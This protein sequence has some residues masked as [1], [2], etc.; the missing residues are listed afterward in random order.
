VEGPSAPGKW[1]EGPS[2]I[3]SC[4]FSEEF[5]LD[6]TEAA[7][8]NYRRRGIRRAQL[9]VIVMRSSG[10]LTSVPKAAQAARKRR[11]IR[12]AAAGPA[13]RVWQ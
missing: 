5:I 10:P 8:V 3:R 6:R 12:A 13:S 7:G 4:R 11:A 2:R 9:Q 1:I